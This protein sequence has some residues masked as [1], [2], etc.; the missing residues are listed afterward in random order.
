M[1][2]DPIEHCVLMM[3]FRFEFVEGGAE[4]SEV[5]GSS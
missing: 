2:S 4:D 3:E 5:L 1:R